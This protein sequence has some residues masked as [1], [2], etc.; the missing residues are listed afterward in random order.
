MSTI[1][2]ATKIAC[3]INPCALALRVDFHEMAY[4]HPILN[5]NFVA[6][7]ITRRFTH[8]AVTIDTDGEWPR[9]ILGATMNERSGTVEYWL[10]QM[11]KPEISDLID[12][13]KEKD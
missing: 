2:D 8:A 10:G 7:H 1:Y 12:R 3:I 4:L 6:A 13:L 11:T 9:V 5:P